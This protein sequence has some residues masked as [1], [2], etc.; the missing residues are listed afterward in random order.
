M[1]ICCQNGADIQ[2][3]ASVASTVSLWEFLTSV[4]SRLIC[5]YIS[6]LNLIG[7][8]G[9]NKMQLDFLIHELLHA[10]LPGV[11]PSID[12]PHLN[13]HFGFTISFDSELAVILLLGSARLLAIIAPTHMHALI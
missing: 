8:H 12:L 2:K 6:C 13:P 11:A 3:L 5:F 4:S 7:R 9:L 10:E 1:S